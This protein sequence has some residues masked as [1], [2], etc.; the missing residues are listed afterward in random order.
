MLLDTEETGREVFV[1]SRTNVVYKANHI[2]QPCQHSEILS[3]KQ[4][5][6]VNFTCL[7]ALF[8]YLFGAMHMCS[9]CM[10]G[11]QG[12][13]STMCILDIKPRPLGLLAS[14]LPIEPHPW[15]S[16]IFLLQGFN[17]IF[18]TEEHRNFLMCVNE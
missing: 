2:G 1:S 17:S 12:T 3:L 15:P 16:F 9:C 8:L 4:N 6:R 7:L 18:G 13:T 10:C 5:K 14:L 11:G